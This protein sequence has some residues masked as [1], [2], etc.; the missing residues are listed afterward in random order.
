MV[1]PH[2]YHSIKTISGFKKVMSKLSKGKVAEKIDQPLFFICQ[3]QGL[4]Y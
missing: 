1:N 3:W 2:Q 4:Y